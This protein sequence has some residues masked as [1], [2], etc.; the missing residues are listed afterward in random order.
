MQPIPG[1]VLARTVAR[2][3]VQVYRL[4]DRLEAI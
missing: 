3:L 1:Y 4:R 2:A